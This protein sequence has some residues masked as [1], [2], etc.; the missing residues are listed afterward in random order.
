LRNEIENLKLA[1]QSQTIETV[2]LLEALRA[3]HVGGQWG[4]IQLR[5]VM[6]LAGMLEHV[7]FEPQKTLTGEDGSVRPDALVHLANGRQVLVDAK[8]PLKAYL[9]AA[10]ERDP[11][12]RAALYKEHA[13][14]LKRHVDLLSLKAYPAHLAAGP[15]FVVVFL[16]LEPMLGAAF[17]QEPGLFDYSVER[18]VLL[19]SPMT[20]LALLKALA[21]GWSHRQLSENAEAIRQSALTVHERLSKFQEH[22]RELGRSL[23]KAAEAYNRAVGSL[24]LRVMPSLRRMEELGVEKNNPLPPLEEI[25]TPIRDKN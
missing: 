25:T 3:P 20:L 5:R 21:Q 12:R 6:E 10:A 18:R 23:G 9:E 19:A 13:R 11:K 7:D 8:A 16:P 4:E 1:Q 14:L 22:L 2:K 17:E 15:E 24:E